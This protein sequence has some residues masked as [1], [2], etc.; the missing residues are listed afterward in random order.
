MKCNFN[1]ENSVLEHLTRTFN[2]LG[3]NEERVFHRDIQ[4]PRSGLKNYGGQEIGY[5][6]KH[7]L[8]FFFD[9]AS[10]TFHNSW[11]NHSY[12]SWQSKSL[13][14]FMLINIQYPNHRHGGDFR[15]FV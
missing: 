2:L 12:N 11:K 5:L 10:Q 9:M 15:C 8:H 6:M 13:Q 4:T 1:N 14:N 7:S 3:R